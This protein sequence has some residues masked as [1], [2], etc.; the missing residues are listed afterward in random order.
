MPQSSPR[1]A[2]NCPLGTHP[3]PCHRQAQ[4]KAWNFA[5]GVPGHS[6]IAR[7]N[8]IMKAR[9]ASSPALLYHRRNQTPFIQGFLCYLVYIRSRSVPVPVPGRVLSLGYPFLVGNRLEFRKRLGAINPSQGP[10]HIHIRDMTLSCS[11]IRQSSPGLLVGS[12][13]AEGRNGGQTAYVHLLFV[14]LN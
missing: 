3:R 4:E 7:P 11:Y 5:W 6:S 9:P 2:S 12:C 14:V 10:E 8:K 1:I 13:K